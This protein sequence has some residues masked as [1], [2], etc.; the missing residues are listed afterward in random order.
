MKRRS[1]IPIFH[2]H[3][4]HKLTMHFAD[5]MLIC[6]SGDTVLEVISNFLLSH[7]YLELCQYVIVCDL[8]LKIEFIE[9]NECVCQDNFANAKAIILIFFVSNR[10]KKQTINSIK[11]CRMS[12]LTLKSFESIQSGILD[13]LIEIDGISYMIK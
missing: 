13:Q 7:T 12:V 9:S 3:F 10:N 6:D 4:R 2:F 8:S 11:I 5:T 1:Y